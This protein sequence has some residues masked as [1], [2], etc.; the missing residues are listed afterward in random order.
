MYIVHF[1]DQANYEFIM[2]LHSSIE[3]AEAAFAA[4]LRRFVVEDGATLPPKADWIGLCDHH[5]EN[6]H[7]Y[8][9]ECDGK[10]AEEIQL[11]GS[12]DLATA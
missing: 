2:S 1:F 7:I 4:L 12:E 9:I 6:P 11:S 10:P 3:A 5:G 8:K